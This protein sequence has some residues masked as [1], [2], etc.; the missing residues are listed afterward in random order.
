MYF[1]RRAKFNKSCVRKCYKYK[2]INHLCPIKSIEAAI[3][4]F[5]LIEYRTN[6][7]SNY[8]DFITKLHR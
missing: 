4:V 8:I 2:L 3:Q 7:I 1:K 5:Y 6:Q